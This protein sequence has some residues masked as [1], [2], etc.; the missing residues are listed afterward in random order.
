MAFFEQCSNPSPDLFYQR[1]DPNDIRLGEVVQIDPDA[2]SAANVILVGCPQDEG[3]RRNKGRVGAAKAPDEIRRAL[4]RLVTPENTNL[5]LFDA[6][7]TLIQSTLE[8]THERHSEIVRKIISDG[9][10]VI[11]LGGGN[12]VSY[13]DCSGLAKAVQPVIAINVDAHFDVRA[14]EIPN[15]GTPYRQLL[16]DGFVQ[17][18]HFY[19]VGS[20]AMAN[21]STYRDYLATKNATI[22]DLNTVLEHGIARI[23]DEILADEAQAIFWG[24]DMD[25]VRAA[26]AP[27]VSA[28]NALGLSAHEICQIATI[29]GRDQRSRVF[30]ITEVNPQYDIDSR[31]A[32]LAAAVIHH[33]LSS[34][35][36]SA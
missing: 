34:L 17:G 20:V 35:V 1:N 14:D 11:S 10:R 8:A 19:E 21:S 7:N 5:K 9:K 30:E 24:I 28:P 15:S 22:Y 27:G 18:E 3:V 29:A 16:E 36:L 12:D 33:F 4:Y 23:L 31:T 26:D 32:R 25:V 13:A 6:G 2:Y